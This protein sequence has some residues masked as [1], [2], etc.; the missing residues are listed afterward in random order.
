MLV[1]EKIK[2]K[3]EDK[4]ILNNI[5]F[6]LEKGERLVMVGQS[7]CGKT[8]LLKTL[9]GLLQPTAGSLYFDGEKVRGPAERLVPGHDRIKLVNQDFELDN[10]HTVTENIRLKL[11]AFDDA[12]KSSR[13]NELLKLTGLQKYSQRLANTLSGG[14]KQRLAIARALADEPDLLLLDEPFNQLDFNLRNK[15]ENYIDVYLKKYNIT[16]IL[17]SHSAEETMRWGEKVMFLKGG[18]VVRTDSPI[19]FYQA[20]TDKLEAGFFG[21]INTVYHQGGDIHFRPHQYALTATKNRDI[22]IAV[23]LEKVVFKGWYYDHVFKVGNRKIYLY[24]EKPLPSIQ[25]IFV[26]TLF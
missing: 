7:G 8:T 22:E 21:I 5:S 12:Y 11:L 9:A 3:F 15:I 13:I 10:F 19:N 18:K 14:Q 25:S 4:I 6:S 26:A 17:V 23:T 20:P 2:V 16:L 1:V 24:N